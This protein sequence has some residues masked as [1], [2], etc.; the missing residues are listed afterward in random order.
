[1]APPFE[2]RRISGCPGP[3]CHSRN[4]M[5]GAAKICCFLENCRLIGFQCRNL[6][7]LLV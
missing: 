2:K 4:K 6:V 7:Y 1:M 5:A 3:V